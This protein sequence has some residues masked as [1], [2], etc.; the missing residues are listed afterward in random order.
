[1]V[2]NGDGGWECPQKAATENEPT[3]VQKVEEETSILAT[4]SQEMIDSHSAAHL[5]FQFIIFQKKMC[6]P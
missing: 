5:D 2:A 6:T 3:Q 1:M 4:S